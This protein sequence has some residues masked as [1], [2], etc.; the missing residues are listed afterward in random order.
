LKKDFKV[1]PFFFSTKKD[2]QIFTKPQYITIS[3]A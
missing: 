2:I 3:E 1:R